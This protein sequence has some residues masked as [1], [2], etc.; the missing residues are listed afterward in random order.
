MNNF[1]KATSSKSLIFKVKNTFEPNM[2][3]WVIKR[4]FITSNPF[5]FLIINV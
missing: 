4:I 2:L 1:V 5:A 3:K